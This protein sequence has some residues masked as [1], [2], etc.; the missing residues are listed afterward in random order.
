M[1]IWNRALATPGLPALLDPWFLLPPLLV[2]APVI[3][4]GSQ[5]DGDRRL[6]PSELTQITACFYVFYA[7]TMTVLLMHEGALSTSAL[8]SMH[9]PA[10]SFDE[11]HFRSAGTLI[12]ICALAVSDRLPTQSALRLVVIGLCGLVTLFGVWWFAEHL[13]SASSFQ[14]DTYSRTRQP[15]VDVRALEY[16]RAR[17]A[18]EG[19]SSL[20]VLN[21]PDAASA[22]PAAARILAIHPDLASEPDERI[23]A[24]RFE[25]RVPGRVY[26]FVDTRL[27]GSTKAMLLLKEFVD[28]PNSRWEPHQ[29][30]GTTI[31]V[32][33]R[34]QP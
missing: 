24:R 15:F 27:A 1:D 6:V 23:A 4:L 16:G 19:R 10:I 12:L 32:Q 17:F 2:L 34:P 33:S 29:F 31:F 18:Q 20:F 14:V 8:L 22:F 30:G 11:R 3:V 7:L 25:G 5:R 21:S 9:G 28:Y 13:H 26:V